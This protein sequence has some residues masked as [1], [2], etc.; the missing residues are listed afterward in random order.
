MARKR[1]LTPDDVVAAA[2][3]LA[4]ADGLEAVT[5]AAVAER[6]S[7]RSPSLYSHVDGLD[8][9]RRRLAFE[10][11]EALRLAFVAAAADRTGL[12]ALEA[13]AHA[14]R[15]FARDHPGLYAAAQRAVEPDE[16][17]ELY[18]ALGAVLEPVLGALLEAGVP[19]GELIHVT[20]AFRSAL[21]G[22]MEL[23]LKGGFGI[24]ESV[25]ESFRHLVGLVLSGIEGLA[26]GGEAPAA[27]D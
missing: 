14:Y 26:A 13:L 1:G 22:F 3:E 21:H 8:G 15:A 17:P 24:P 7:V 2:R 27:Q 10:A 9:L 4:D 6:L 20:R 18:A 25:E 19:E 12:E 16:D 11:A 5:L 23:E